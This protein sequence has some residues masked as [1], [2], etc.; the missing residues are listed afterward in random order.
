M[1]ESGVPGFS[2][3][4]WGGIFAPAKLPPA[5]A[6][7]L[8]REVNLALAQSE[9]RQQLERQQFFAQ[10]STSQELGQFTRE[11]LDAYKRILRDAG[12]EPE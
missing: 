5:I 1:A 12:V 11:Q 8:T 7:R 10:G 9:V 3:T 2:I 4:L 6:E